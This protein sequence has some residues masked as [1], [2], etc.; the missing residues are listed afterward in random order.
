MALKK[1]YLDLATGTEIT[2]SRR[3]QLELLEKSSVCPQM[4]DHTWSPWKNLPVTI[5]SHQLW[6]SLAPTMFYVVGS[7]DR[8]IWVGH[9]EIRDVSPS[10]LVNV[11]QILG[12]PL[13]HS[14]CA[15]SAEAD[16]WPLPLARDV[17]V[18]MSMK[19]HSL[20]SYP[21]FLSQ[22]RRR[23]L[24]KPVKSALQKKTN[25]DCISRNKSR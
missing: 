23:N 22:P 6:D 14:S 24:D 11:L 17:S 9:V 8:Y 1:T 4:S 5:S 15:T 7:C 3:K 18:A 2:L 19:T 25:S 12:V 20:T 21:G 13:L 10:L 16:P